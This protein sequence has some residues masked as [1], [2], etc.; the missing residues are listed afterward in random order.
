MNNRVLIV[1]TRAGNL[2][3]LRASIERLG[4][5]TVTANS[6]SDEIFSSIVIP[7]QGRFGTVMENLKS[8][9]WI[10]Y[11]YQEK[12]KGQRI[13]GICVGMQ[14]FFEKSAE[15][16]GVAGLGWLKGEVI[17]PNFP[18]KPMIGWAQLESNVWPD[19]IVYFVNSYAVKTSEFCI[20]KTFY[21]ES[22]CAAVSNKNI[23]GMQFHP[24]KSGATGSKLMRQL[25]TGALDD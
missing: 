23:F 6:P 5:Q 10:D 17:A 18:K 8:N 16:P 9:G 22:F 2:Y 1:N 21:G 3:S 19:E 12:E 7:G 13:I 24:E 15:D 11:L 14:I 20:A 25:L 4:F